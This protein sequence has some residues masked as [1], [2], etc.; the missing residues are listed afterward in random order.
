MN[1]SEDFKIGSLV[2]RKE[3]YQS[4]KARRPIEIIGVIVKRKKM[5]WSKHLKTYGFHYYIQWND[6]TDSVFEDKVLDAHLK[7]GYITVLSKG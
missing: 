2:V 3:K 1:M 4:W 7:S 5:P 6:G